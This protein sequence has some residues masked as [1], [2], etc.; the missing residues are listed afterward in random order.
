MKSI[1]VVFALVRLALHRRFVNVE[2]SI[3]VDP[4]LLVCS[5]GGVATT[6]LMAHIAKFKDINDPD[7]LD[8]LKHPPVPPRGAAKILFISGPDQLVAQSIGRRGWLAFQGAKLGSL[9]GLLPPTLRVMYFQKAVRRQ[10]AS[11]HNLC[12]AS[13]VLYI[14][15]DK[16][17]VSQ[18]IIANFFEIDS[19]EFISRFPKLRNRLSK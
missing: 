19:P 3:G 13:E 4:T 9:C 18:Q 11:F 8:G 15:W 6:T 7:D 2:L 5:P 10:T 1:K 16:I 17:W 12:G 14:P